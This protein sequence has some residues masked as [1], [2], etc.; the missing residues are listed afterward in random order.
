VKTDDLGRN[1]SHRRQAHHQ[2]GA[3]R[4]RDV[5][6]EVDDWPGYRERALGVG[7]RAI[8]AVPMRAWGQTIGVLD[9][10]R[11]SPGPW[12]LDDLDAAEILTA[13]ASGYILHADQMRSQHDLTSSTPPCG[14]AT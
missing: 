12:D 1:S 4:S 11:K 7:W 5:L 14:A 10:Y 6:A 13:M 3:H 9:I 8:V 2:A